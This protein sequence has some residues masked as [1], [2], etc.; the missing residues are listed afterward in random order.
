MLDRYIPQ[1]LMS[2]SAGTLLGWQGKAACYVCR[3]HPH[4]G[5]CHLRAHQ[6][7]R[8]RMCLSQVGW[9]A[10]MVVLFPCQHHIP[11]VTR[12]CEHSLPDNSLCSRQELMCWQ[13]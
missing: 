13:A 4:T 7:V 10:G 8:Q 9:H 2:K 1:G 3:A 5:L 6:V 12:S 11:S